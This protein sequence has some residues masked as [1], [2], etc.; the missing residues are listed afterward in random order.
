M[1]R[2]R[3]PTDKSQGPGRGRKSTYDPKIGTQI[4]ALLSEG[5]FLSDA[6]ALVKVP[7]RTVE[8]WIHKGNEGEEP[9]VQFAQ[10]VA[11]ARAQFTHLALKDIRVNGGDKTASIRWHLSKLQ[12]IKF[13][14]RVQVH[15]T[16]ALEEKLEALREAF[17]P[18]TYARIVEVL[19]GESRSTGA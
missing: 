18:E 14:D 5:S 3:A 15:L 8:D 11:Q 1:S 17:P 4:C 2:K 6:C 7:A 12:P 13:G 10:E 9:Y 19:A 16:N